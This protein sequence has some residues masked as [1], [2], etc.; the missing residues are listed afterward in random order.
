[1]SLIGLR[2]FSQLQGL[3]RWIGSLSKE[4]EIV[5]GEI[6]S[7]IGFGKPIGHYFFEG[8]GVG[9][10]LKKIPTQKKRLKKNR[11]REAIG[12]KKSSKRF[13]LLLRFLMFKKILYKLTAQEKNLHNLKVK[14]GK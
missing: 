10:F 8:V 12:K 13:L 11:A 5:I 2:F 3:A 6:P 1:M 9:N 14:K 4:F 7:F